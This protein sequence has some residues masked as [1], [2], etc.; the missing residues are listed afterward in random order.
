MH[1]WGEAET[2][3]HPFGT[4]G[5]RGMGELFLSRLSLTW[6]GRGEQ[7]DHSRAPPVIQIKGW[8]GPTE[9]CPSS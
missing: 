8:K 2:R 9:T 7:E 6:G 1:R 5:G 4:S 3:R